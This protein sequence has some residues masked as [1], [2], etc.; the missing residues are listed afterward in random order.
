MGSEWHNPV[1]RGG[2][3]VTTRIMANSIEFLQFF[4][5]TSIFVNTDTKGV[6]EPVGRL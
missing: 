4:Y 3:S 5:W 6:F 2:L 1:V